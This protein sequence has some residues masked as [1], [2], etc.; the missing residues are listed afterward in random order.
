[1]IRRE[2]SEDK[3]L[4]LACIH[5]VL[6]LVLAL[7]LV[8]FPSNK[9]KFKKGFACAVSQCAASPVVVVIF[10][11]ELYTERSYSVPIFRSIMNTQRR[12]SKI[13]FCAKEIHVRP[14]HTHACE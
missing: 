12:K 1:M 8:K 2:I 6:A 7:L 14:P 4:S 11:S 3:V 10:H 9:I 5:F 13:S